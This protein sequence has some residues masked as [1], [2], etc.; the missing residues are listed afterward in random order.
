M[1][2]TN[3]VAPLCVIFHHNSVIFRFLRP[4]VILSALMSKSDIF[5]SLEWKIGRNLW[6]CVLY[7]HKTYITSNEYKVQMLR[8]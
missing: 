8:Y 2:N 3:F 4:N 6:L 7:A 1:E 5:S